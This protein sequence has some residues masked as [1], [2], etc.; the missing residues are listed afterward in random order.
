MAT[1][2]RPLGWTTLEE[3]EALIK[4]GLNPISADMHYYVYP[5]EGNRAGLYVGYDSHEAL[6][7]V[8]RD[9]YDYIPAWSFCTLWKLLPQ[10]IEGYGLEAYRK[11]DNKEVIWYWSEDY[12]ED[13]QTYCSDYQIESVVKMVLWCLS[14]GYIKK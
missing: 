8:R 13:L 14:N 7:Y 5:K 9:V 11:G 1:N 6:D 10:Y 12:I 3:S 4:A 2:D